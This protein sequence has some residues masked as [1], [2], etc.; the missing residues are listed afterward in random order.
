MDVDVAV[1]EVEGMTSEV[2][3]M[4][5]STVASTTL[6]VVVEMS[7]SMVEGKTLVVVGMSNNKVGVVISL[8]EVV[9]GSSMEV[10]ET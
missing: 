2:V 9:S 10:D 8:E 6:V 3:A 4:S 1:G 5:S 7:S